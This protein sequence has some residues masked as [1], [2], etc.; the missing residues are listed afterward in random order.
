MK[1]NQASEIVAT[2]FGMLFKVLFTLIMI[3]LV[4]RAGTGAY[5]FGYDVFADI[6]A[7]LS[8]GLTKHVTITEDLSQWEVAKLLEENAIVTDAKVF[9]VQLILSDYKDKIIAGTHELNSS[10]QSEEI[11]LVITGMAASEDEE[12]DS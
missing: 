7:Q 6:P 11:M 5:Q 10:M 2:V 12:S 8:P 9:Y 3:M 4:Y 1:A